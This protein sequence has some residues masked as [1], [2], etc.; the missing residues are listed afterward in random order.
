MVLAEE[1]SQNWLFLFCLKVTY[2]V[3]ST[4]RVRFQVLLNSVNEYDLAYRDK[5]KQV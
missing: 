2:V 3:G 5:H 1:V 4:D